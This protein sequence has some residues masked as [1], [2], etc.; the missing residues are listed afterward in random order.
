MA[1]FLKNT[2]Q[3]INGGIQDFNNLL[4]LVSGVKEAS[5]LDLLQELKERQF[6]LA[7]TT[8][9]LKWCLVNYS[10]ISESVGVLLMS[11]IRVPCGPGNTLSPLNTV[12]YYTTPHQ[13]AINWT[14]PSDCVSREMSGMLTTGE[15]KAL[16]VE[17][18]SLSTW[19]RSHLSHNGTQHSATLFE[20]IL[21]V[22]SS[23]HD[24]DTEVAKCCSL[25]SQLRCIP[26]TDNKLYMPGEVFMEDAVSFGM[27]LP[28][29]HF[30]KRHLISDA[31]LKGLGVRTHL[32]IAD[33]LSLIESIK[34]EW[35]SVRL[36][37]YLATIQD[38]IGQDELARLRQ[39]PIFPDQSNKRRC[40]P[41]L[42]RDSK[43]A[44]AIRVPVLERVDLM[45]ER[46][47]RLMRRLGFQFYI[48]LDLLLES[49]VSVD[50]EPKQRL[51][52]YEYLFEHFDSVYKDFAF[53][54]HKVVWCCDNTMRRPGQCFTDARC[55]KLLG[56]A[57]AR[58]EIARYC[59]HYLHVKRRPC[60][61][62]IVEALKTV[63]ICDELVDL[64]ADCEDYSQSDYYELSML[65]LI[66]NGTAT[67]KHSFFKV[68]PDFASIFTTVSPDMYQGKPRTRH[69]LQ[70]IGVKEEPHANELMIACA[71]QQLLESMGVKRYT[72]LLRLFAV[73]LEAMSDVAVERFK[74]GRALLGICYGAGGNSGSGA[75][76]T[77]TTSTTP[78]TTASLYN[79]ASVYIGDDPVSQRNFQ[80]PV[81]PADDLH[82]FY[83][84]MGC[85]RVSEC[86]QVSWMAEGAIHVDTDSDSAVMALIRARAKVIVKEGLKVYE[87]ASVVA[88]AVRHLLTLNI[89]T[90][91]RIRV[92]KRFTGSCGGK[93]EHASTSTS[94]YQQDGHCLY[95]LSDPDPF[96]LAAS[97]VDSLNAFR[98]ASAGSL[99]DTL[100]VSTL[101]TMPMEA[102]VERGFV[103]RVD[104]GVEVGDDGGSIGG[105]VRIEAPAV[106][107]VHQPPVQPVVQQ[108]KPKQKTRL[109]D[110]ILSV[111]SIPPPS[112]VIA[113]DL[114]YKGRLP[115]SG[116]E[117]YGTG[118]TG[119]GTDNHQQPPPEA[120]L[121][122]THLLTLSTIFS[123]PS[124][125][126][127]IFY[128]PH[129]HSIAFNRG[130]SLFFNAHFVRNGTG[131]GDLPFWYMTTC[132]ELAHN[133]WGP[134]DE[135][136]EHYMASYAERFLPRL[137]SHL[138]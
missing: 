21:A 14:I 71:E 77:N 68:P 101:L 51:I 44:R 32:P 94:C 88:S 104:G 53:T 84:A 26:S 124:S 67:A 111:F 39:A 107:P 98:S 119:S 62:V 79:P 13:S 112:C 123:L 129:S 120:H 118:S 15:W 27:A 95:T 117:Y 93:R 40:M 125:A 34:H 113:N 30:K 17:P 35:D 33:L 10:D 91:A 55:E 81:A 28:T 137:V 46:V 25:L 100:L 136:H 65:K 52:L 131:G 70:N 78:N 3:P 64:L 2:P 83:Q 61:A 92:L 89:C 50:C 122:A 24:D 20:D 41:E 22:I 127:H 47:V 108:A 130:G 57:V 74:G 37:G 90:C 110:K 102:L 7:E 18:L 9:A 132:H 31:V 5:V 38:D 80:I 76:T 58:E 60:G 11:L 121:L 23:H 1:Q 42:H 66:N 16:S 116:I 133:F 109:L 97:I 114:I 48:K 54:D 69:F 128:D 36:L 12:K 56:L 4:S 126:L 75:S 138:R 59:E 73:H 106:P 115:D 8:L 85:K 96:D 43:A 45:D 87:P 6:T 99:S 72:A 29:V 86:V 19:L 63:A 135:R 82:P 134:H 105:D 103:D 49:L